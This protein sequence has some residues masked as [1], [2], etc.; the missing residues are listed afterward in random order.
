MFTDVGH[1]IT[2]CLRCL[3]LMTTTISTGTAAII[4][5]PYKHEADVDPEMFDADTNFANSVSLKFMD[6]KFRPRFIIKPN[7]KKL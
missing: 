7:Y 1:E 4:Y 6:D 5:V 2:V 3:Y